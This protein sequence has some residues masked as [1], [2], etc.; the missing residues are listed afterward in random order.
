MIHLEVFAY[1]T[2]YT[3]L[4]QLL[5]PLPLSIGSRN[6]S[7]AVAQS[8]ETVRDKAIVDSAVKHASGDELCV[9]VEYL[10]SNRSDVRRGQDNFS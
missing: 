2:K 7:D 4:R 6:G 5:L 1:A 9:F 10:F 8:L 3:L